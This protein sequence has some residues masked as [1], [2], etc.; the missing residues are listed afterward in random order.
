MILDPQ[1]NEISLQPRVI[2]SFNEAGYERY[3]REFV[4]SYLANWPKNIGLTVYYEGEN[5]PFTEGLSWHPMESVEYLAE[6]LANLRFPIM[7]GIVGNHF[8]MWFDARQARKVFMEMHA[9]KNY[10]GKIFWLDADI[11]THAPVPDGFLDDM[12][13]DDKFCCYLGRDG[14]YHTESGFIGFNAKHPIANKFY[15]AYVNTFISGAIFANLVHGR[16]GWNDC[17]G[18]D[19]IRLLLNKPEAFV[20]L[21]KD[22]PK[23]TMHP[24]VNTKLGK[25][26]DHRKGPRKESKSGDD[27]LVIARDEPYWQR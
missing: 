4:E 24:F 26:M 5:F 10:G 11:V 27:D 19:G 2:T 20:N 25:F 8:D 3:G 6:Y 17:C 9:M 16:C 15:N 22:L 13:P 21:A 12:L 18:F 1:G 7:H 14:W 23:G